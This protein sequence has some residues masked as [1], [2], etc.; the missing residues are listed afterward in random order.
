M[1]TFKSLS[2]SFFLLTTIFFTF[3]HAA[4]FNVKNNCPFTLWAALLPLQARQERIW[5]RTNCNFD[6][7]GQGKCETGDCNGL[8]QRQAFGTPPTTLAEYALNQFN[9]LDFF[10][11]SHVDGYNV[12]M[13][14]SPV[15]GGCTRGIKC[16]MDMNRDCP[17]ELTAPVGC[18]NPCT[19][20]KTDEYC[21]YS[22]KCGPTNNSK[23]FKDRCPDTYSYPK[24]GN[25]CTFTC[26]GGTNYEKP[27]G[28]L[29][30]SDEFPML[31]DEFP[32]SRRGK[33]RVGEDI[34]DNFEVKNDE[35]A[36]VFSTI[37]ENLSGLEE[38]SMDIEVE[39]EE[40]KRIG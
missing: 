5:A 15:S 32:C 8:L 28:Y 2:I 9:N 16:P 24:D 25:N 23:F 12:P 33:K 21:C 37:D 14:F 11:I 35:K 4:T 22:E 1:T 26:P 39:V 36:G 18:N 6:G 17:N 10:D 19:V 7:A 13:E 30:I 34:S 40:S 31:D 29:T 3:T 20:F 38:V 27:V